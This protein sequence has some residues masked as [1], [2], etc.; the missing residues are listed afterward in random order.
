M[1]YSVLPNWLLIPSSVFFISVIVFFISELFSF[2][3]YSSL[4]KFSPCSSNL[5]PN[6][7]GILITISLSSY[8]GKLLIFMSFLFA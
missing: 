2:I 3:L 4:L 5:L 6:L 8:S 1:P 7:V